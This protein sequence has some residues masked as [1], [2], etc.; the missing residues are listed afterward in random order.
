MINLGTLLIVCVLIF[1]A[2]FVDAIAGG[3]GLISLPAYLFAGFP[4]HTA[5]GSNKFSSCAG[6]A[7]AGIKYL[8]EGKV[9]MS[10][11]LWSAL[12]CIIGAGAG[13][14]L[15]LFFSDRTLHMIVLVALP[16][17]AVFLATR[18]DLGADGKEVMLDRKK[19][20]ILAT[21]IGIAVG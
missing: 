3:G 7:S 17:V 6:L 9:R 12:G 1:L 16:I 10:V 19:E 20:A 18:K 8:K 14:R 11:A 5:I 21:V 2:G 4:V 13:T 15:G